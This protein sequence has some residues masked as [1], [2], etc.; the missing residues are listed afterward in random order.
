MADYLTVHYS[1]NP[2]AKHAHFEDETLKKLKASCKETGFT[3]HPV[4]ILHCEWQ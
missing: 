2:I 3:N 1:G 4:N